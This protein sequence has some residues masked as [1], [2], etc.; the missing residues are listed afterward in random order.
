M[1]SVSCSSSSLKTLFAYDGSG[2]TGGSQRY[3][4]AA[5]QLYKDLPAETTDILFW[6]SSSHIITP[7]VLLRINTAR[8]GN[9]GTCPERIASHVVNTDFHGHLVILT[10]G[11][12]SN[13]SV[14]ACDRILPTG[15]TFASV[16][17]LMVDTGGA[18]NMSVGCP[19]TR[20]SPHTVQ[21]LADGD[22]DN[23]AT[24]ANTITT[25]SPDMLAL[26][27]RLDSI[28]TVADWWAVATALEPVIIARTMGST[29]DPTLRDRLLTLKARIQRADAITKGASE[30]VIRLQT[31]LDTNDMAVAMAM[32][33][34]LTA[35]YYGGDDGVDTTSWSGQLNRLV[36][37]CEGALRGTFDLSNI[38]GA[39]QSD[40]ARRA[41]AARAAPTT[42]TELSE[43]VGG[44][45]TAAA[46]A[47]VCPITMDSEA[48]VVL[49]VAAD[50]TPLLGGGVDKDT[51]TALAN[52]PLF[53]FRYPE[54]LA[55]FQARVDH[56]LSLRALKEA[57]AI[58]ASI[59][60]SPMTRRPLL[61]GLCL[62]PHE[63]HVAATNWTLAQLTAD[64]R[65]LGS[66]DLWFAALWLLVKRGAL[67][68]L[69]SV[70]PQMTVH[71]AYRLRNSKA[72][73][74]LLG[75]PEFPTTHVPLD[76][77]LWYAVASSA[78]SPPPAREVVR[79]HLP[80][81][82]ELMEIGAL[83]G[84]IYPEGTLRHLTRLRV[85]LAALAWSKRNEPALRSALRALYQAAIRNCDVW[86]PIDGPTSLAQREAVMASLP[87]LFQRLPP[88]ELVAIGALV[89]PRKSAA[90]VELHFDWTAPPLPAATVSWAYGLIEYPANQ[91]AI[92]PATCR[93][94]Y[95]VPPT[96][97][98][99][100]DVATA[101]MGGITPD[102]MLSIHTEYGRYVVK[103]VAYPTKQELLSH[104]WHRVSAQGRPTLPAQI[105]AFVDDILSDFRALV[106]E[107]PPATFASRF[108]ASVKR[109]D[110]MRMET[111]NV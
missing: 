82:E 63:D 100:R 25:V 103:H 32:A 69:R 56:P 13:S 15:W 99:W 18:I 17:V 3:H 80:Y 23:L 55:A 96:G 98:E 106:T 35:E 104:L 75:T 95:H 21:K 110:R 57:E 22:G 33:D 7:A 83:S 6:D 53:L 44:V 54:L 67:P 31:A 14:D 92:C 48:D 70:L 108:Q 66:P 78:L 64:G 11:Q 45:A 47:F 93:P 76:L 16:R 73:I 36:S 26:L 60:D 5:Q 107:L 72:P 105:E 87:Q 79:A 61:G 10:D 86:L 58:G 37:M 20:N 50:S 41:P 28:A 74:S 71:L 65:R 102:Q 42:D 81:V 51:V 68:Y 43:P 34:V 39:I 85:T 8:L 40:R 2:S 29:G 49:M 91:V 9:G 59:A 90:D 38:N 62:G 94:Y 101:A 97:E 24:A 30:T 27:D 88:A 46:A 4:T 12:V 84:Y 1:T 52:C 89:N 77:A 19:F 109:A 111:S